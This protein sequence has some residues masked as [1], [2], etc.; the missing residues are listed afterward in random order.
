MV[1]SSSTHQ[2]T[3]DRGRGALLISRGPR[4]HGALAGCREGSWSCQSAPPRRRRHDLETLPWCGLSSRHRP[5]QPVRFG[6]GAS[7]RRHTSGRVVDMDTRCPRCPVSPLPW[8]WRCSVA[9]LAVAVA[10]PGSFGRHREPSWSFGSINRRTWCP[11]GHTTELN[12]LSTRRYAVEPPPPHVIP[13]SDLG[14][15]LEPPPHPAR[16]PKPVGVLHALAK[17]SDHP[18]T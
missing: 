12:A 17:P 10:P 8:E 2:A 9:H 5:P 11:S 15:A 6:Y 7:P 16:P 13:I 18:K 3:R 14:L 4:T 1:R